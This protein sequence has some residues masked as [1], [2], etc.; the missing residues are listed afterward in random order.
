MDEF[1]EN[2]KLLIKKRL[3]EFIKNKEYE[4]FII[5]PWG[6]ITIEKL[7][8]YIS[9]GKMIRGGLILWSYEIYKKQIN[10]D[11]IDLALA[12]EFIQSGF[13]IH[14]DIMDKDQNRR[15]LDTIHYQFEKLAN[16]Y[17]IVDKSH[18]GLSMGICA[19]DLSFFIAFEIISHLK[20][21]S[22]IIKKIQ[23][24]IY[25]EINKVVLAQMQD[26]YFGLSDIIPKV[27][28]IIILY[29]YKTARYTFSL[30]LILGSI[31]CGRNDDIIFL[32]EKIGEILGILF[33]IKDDELGL[34]G[35]S[36]KT[37]KPIGSDILQ[38][39]KTLFYHYLFNYLKDN[40]LEEIKNIYSKNNITDN[41]LKILKNYLENKN[42]KE[43]IESRILSLI[44]TYNELIFDK[45][46]TNEEK[47]FFVKLYNFVIERKK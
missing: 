34:F 16:S 33:Q 1:F 28:D 29:M 6:K 43:K 11:I 19:G 38:K 36:K 35:D 45:N 40:E 9:N 8:E 22:D 30:P 42:I 7:S 39:K 15:G 46:L 23:Q 27:E 4:F 21:S 37:G 24:Y 25:K 14:D 18:F 13:L 44:N 12:Y 41:D 47:D 31:C 26:M 10:T 2:Y 17:N 20:F 5:H 32:F 3:W